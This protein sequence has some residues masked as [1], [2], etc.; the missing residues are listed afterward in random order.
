MYGFGVKEDELINQ[1]DK[2]R[3]NTD[4]NKVKVAFGTRKGVIGKE[5]DL[6]YWIKDELKKGDLDKLN[7]LLKEKGINYQF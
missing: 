6:D 5:Y 4:F 7:N 3:N 1:F 2:L